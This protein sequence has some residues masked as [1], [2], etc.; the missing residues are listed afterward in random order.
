M[1]EQTATDPAAEL[2]AAAEQCRADAAAFGTALPAALAP[3]LAETAEFLDRV[4][5]THGHVDAL[6]LHNTRHALATARAINAE[7]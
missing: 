1:P 3:W 5:Q 2:R 7:G 6:A 4:R